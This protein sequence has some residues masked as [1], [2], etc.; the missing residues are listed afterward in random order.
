MFVSVVEAHYHSPIVWKAHY[1][2]YIGL[3]G[4]HGED[5]AHCLR[6]SIADKTL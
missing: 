1:Q 3:W 6:V 4:A 2:T 5:E